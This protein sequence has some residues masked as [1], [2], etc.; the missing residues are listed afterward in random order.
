MRD[1]HLREPLFHERVDRVQRL[2]RRAAGEVDERAEPDLR[3][4]QL[5]LA[6][7]ASLTSKNG[8]ITATER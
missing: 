2:G 8:T 5:A 1:E 3:L 7:G 6:P 4:P